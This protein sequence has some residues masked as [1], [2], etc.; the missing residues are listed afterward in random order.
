MQFE[1]ARALASLAFL[2]EVAAV[3]LA[4]V[5]VWRRLSPVQ[6]GVGAVLMACVPALLTSQPATG[7]RLA[8]K[9]AL[10]QLSV[11]PDPLV[12]LVL[13]VALHLA[14]LVL[15]T[16]SVC[17]RTGQACAAI[18]GL[19]LLGRS[20]GD[21]PLGALLLSLSALILLLLDADSGDPTAPELAGETV[22]AT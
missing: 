4:A 12:P 16:L 21:A 7:F 1:V 14:V 18:I 17:T 19:A 6:R 10:E 15:V 5:W 20:S 9:R 3:A 2:A 13:P 8:V 11:H 22:D